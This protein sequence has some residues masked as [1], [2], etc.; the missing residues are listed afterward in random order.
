MSIDLRRAGLRQPMR[1]HR[2]LSRQPLG[3]RRSP[4]RRADHAQMRPAAPLR[5]QVLGGGVHAHVQPFAGDA[6]REP[7]RLVGKTRLRALRV[8]LHVR[9]ARLQQSVRRRRPLRRATQQAPMPQEA[10]VLA[11]VCRAGVQAKVG[12]GPRREQRDCCGIRYITNTHIDVC[13][14][15][16]RTHYLCS[17]AKVRFGA[18]GP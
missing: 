7:P 11:R 14:G 16:V 17:G 13:V 12:A 4:A 10:P 5:P 1:Q 3:P 2:P 18:Q 9:Y 8:S 6:R 15:T